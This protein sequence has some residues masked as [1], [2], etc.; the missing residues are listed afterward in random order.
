[1][2]RVDRIDLE[3][4]KNK[5]LELAKKVVLE[6]KYSIDEVEYVIGVDQA[7]VGDYVIS[8]AVKMTFPELKKVEIVHSLDVAE[9]PYIPTFLMFREGEPALKAVKKVLSGKCVI[10]VDGSGIAHPRKCGLATYIAVKTGEPSIGIT[11]K[12]LYGEIAGSPDR[13]ELREGENVIGYVLKTCKRC[14][15]IYIS[16]GSFISPRM[17]LKITEM[18]LRGRKLPEPVRLAHVHASELKKEILREISDRM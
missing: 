1:M 5:Q 3:E 13:A 7:F 6:D 16:P 8:S 2:N 11:K 15:P 9:F 10:I 4:L 17:S 14:N 12:K 18:C